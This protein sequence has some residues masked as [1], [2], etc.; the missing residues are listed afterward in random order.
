[1]VHTT[2][3]NTGSKAADIMRYFLRVLGWRKGGYHAIIERD[4][5]LVRFYDY[6]QMEAT[7]GILPDKGGLGLSNL[8]CIHVAYVGGVSNTNQNEAV[9]NI[10]SA[11]EA[12]LLAYISEVIARYSWVKVVGH[13]QLNRKYCPSFWV[14]D[15]LLARN[16]KLRPRLI[17]EDVFGIKK[18]VKSLPHP[19]GFYSQAKC[20]HCGHFLK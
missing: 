20:P 2:A 19:I 9:C 16:P 8:T 5:T 3:S 10:T 15:W 12:T 7:N 14:P 4:G 6:D 1:M 11:Q 13:N 18:A 17:F